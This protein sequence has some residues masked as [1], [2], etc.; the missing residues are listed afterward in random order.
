MKSY[1]NVKDMPIGELEKEDG[2][3]HH[4]NCGGSRR[5]VLHYD[6]KGTHC[7]E[8]RCEINKPKE[9]KVRNIGVVGHTGHGRTTL[10]QALLQSLTRVS[11]RGDK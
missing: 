3:V 7:S 1:E 5:H 2:T 9:P 8:P 6:S 4:L 11:E 10:T